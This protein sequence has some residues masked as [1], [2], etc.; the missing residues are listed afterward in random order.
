MRKLTLKDLHA[1]D[2][3]NILKPVKC[4]CGCGGY[5]YPVF[6]GHQDYIDAMASL[7]DEVECNNAIMIIMTDISVYFAHKGEEKINVFSLPKEYEMN[8]DK[9]IDFVIEIIESFNPHC[10]GILQY[11][12]NDTYRIVMDEIYDN[13]KIL[14][15]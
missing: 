10:I 14:Y 7:L 11:R 6:E 12:I 15:N 13:D 2:C 1:E 3:N 8:L 5:I 9:Q 4:P